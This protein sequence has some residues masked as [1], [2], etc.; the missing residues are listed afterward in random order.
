MNREYMERMSAKELDEYA[1]SCGIDVA[2]IKSKQDKLRI[3]AERRER[4]ATV[5]ALG[6]D[7]E[8][9]VKRVHDKRLSDLMN[10]QNMTDEDMTEAMV[11]LLGQEQLDE[12]V[13]ACTDED[14]TVDVNAM[15]TAYV[16]IIT[17]K[18]LKNF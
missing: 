9:P 14:G 8:I 13:S 12:L 5:R 1:K 6:I 7:F 11:M 4:V 10:K 2:R 3:I 17:A 15:G 16:R 18:E